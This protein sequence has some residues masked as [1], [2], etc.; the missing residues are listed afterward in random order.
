MDVWLGQ[1]SFLLLLLLLLDIK[2][3]DDSKSPNL[4]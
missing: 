3:A 4:L 1:N 2:S